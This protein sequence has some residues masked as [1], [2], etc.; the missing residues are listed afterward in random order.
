LL[1]FW[2]LLLPPLLLLL[3][4]LLLLCGSLRHTVVGLALQFPVCDERCFQKN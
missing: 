4:L 2:L 1:L 3:L